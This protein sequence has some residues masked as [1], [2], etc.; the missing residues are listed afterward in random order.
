MVLSLINDIRLVHIMSESKNYKNA[1][2][3]KA[4]I[5]SDN[6]INIRCSKYSTIMDYH[7]SG[8]IPLYGGVMDTRD[9]QEHHPRR[10]YFVTYFCWFETWSCDM[11]YEQVDSTGELYWG[12]DLYNFDPMISTECYPTVLR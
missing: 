5:Y 6:C 4:K 7:K 12:D 10:E 2:R 3:Y 11:G 9:T 8:F 1:V